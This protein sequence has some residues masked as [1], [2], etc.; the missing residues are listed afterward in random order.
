[1]GL[2]GCLVE[3][4]GPWCVVRF[5]AG[6]LHRGLGGDVVSWLCVAAPAWWPGGDR[7]SRILRCSTM[8]AVVFHG[9]VRDGI[10]CINHAMTTGPPGR[11]SN[12]EWCDW[13]RVVW[14]GTRF[15][16]VRGGE[17][18][19]LRWCLVWRSIGRLGPLG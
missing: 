12:W 7:L 15:G 19:P 5:A 18:L 2:L 14:F 10:G 6:L 1:M 3:H 16:A 13:V 4:P 11:S 17:L 9:R 8:G